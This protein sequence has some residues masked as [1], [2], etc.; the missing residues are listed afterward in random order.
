MDQN[1]VLRA[2]EL[3]EKHGGQ[4]DEN[5]SYILELVDLCPGVIH[6]P[7]GNCIMSSGNVLE[8]AFLA[9]VFIKNLESNDD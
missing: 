7:G 2:K 6:K 1:I 8:F 3:M 4:F 5:M 9:Y